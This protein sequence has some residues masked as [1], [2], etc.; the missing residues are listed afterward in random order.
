LLKLINKAYNK[1]RKFEWRRKM[2]AYDPIIAIGAIAAILVSLI[3]GFLAWMIYRLTLRYQALVTIQ[4]D[5]RSNQMGYAVNLL[6]RFYR[7]CCQGDA[8]TL[9]TKYNEFYKK[10]QKEVDE[11]EGVEKIAA[12]ETTLDNQRRVVS[13]FYSHLA[14]LYANKI[15]PPKYIFETWSKHTLVI[16]PCILIPMENELI[17]IINAEGKKLPESACN[18]KLKEL[19]GLDENSKL[20]KLY[21][22]SLSYPNMT[23]EKKQLIHD[24]D[25]GTASGV[26]AGFIV[27]VAV[28]ALGAGAPLWLGVLAVIG[29]WLIM[30]ISVRVIVWLKYRLGL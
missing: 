21:K 16:I 11:K 18:G 27:A 19:P 17:D 7:E 30:T 29:V 4:K 26:I 6:W 23:N 1:S 12:R 9:R 22:K 10:E 8:N 20:Y 28:L 24:L 14:D 25:I 15:L 3:V 2:S 13:H 5:Y